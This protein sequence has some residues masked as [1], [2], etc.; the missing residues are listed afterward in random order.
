MTVTMPRNTDT[1]VPGAGEPE[2]VTR[3]SRFIWVAAL[4]ML[5][6]LCLGLLFNLLVV[7]QVIHGRD[8]QVIY[9]DFRVDLANAMAPVGQTDVDGALLQMGDPVG[10]IEIP[11]IGVQE[12]V[13]EGT[14]STVMMSGPGH[15]R[16][17]VLPG[18][19]GTSVIYGREAA[20]GGPFGDLALLQPDDTIGVTTA[21]GVAQ[22]A[23]LD[24]RRPGD[25]LPPAIQAGQGRLMLVTAYGPRYMPTDVLR[26]DAV[27]ITDPQPAAARVLAS[28]AMEPAEQPMSGNPGALV[29]LLLWGQLLVLAVVGCVWLLLSW[30]RWQAWLV[31]APVIFFVGVMAATSALQ[32]LPNLM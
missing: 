15:R 27:L 22:Y 18:Q 16:D 20:F 9:A 5:A 30:G 32:L 6:L 17:T 29:P 26:V 25:P 21:Q 19:V 13:L 4:F 7:S 12:V 31:A 8:Q 24:V 14:T 2:D 23:V 10:V 3:N 11:G 1:P 28:S